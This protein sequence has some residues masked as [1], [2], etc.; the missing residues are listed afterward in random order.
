MP[1]EIVTRTARYSLGDDGIVRM[2]SL[3]GA[4]ETLADAQENLH[5]VETL[6]GSGRR[7]PMLS[8]VRLLQTIDRQARAFYGAPEFAVVLSAVAVIVGSPATRMLTN[9]ILTLYKPR[10]PVRLFTSEP[11][12]VAWIKSLP[13]PG[14]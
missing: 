6:V 2:S 7:C 9:F 11:E 14:R 5:A 3:P 10:Y 8:D 13:L 1:R 4:R 12:A